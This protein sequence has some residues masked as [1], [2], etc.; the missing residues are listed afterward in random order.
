MYLT[1]HPIQNICHRLLPI[2]HMIARSRCECKQT[3]TLRERRGILSCTKRQKK[4]FQGRQ[5]RNGERDREG[6]N[7]KMGKIEHAL[8][9]SP[10]KKA[11]DTKILR[12]MRRKGARKRGVAAGGDGRIYKQNGSYLLLPGPSWMEAFSQTGDPPDALGGP[13]HLAAREIASM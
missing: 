5:G 9:P 11:R 7:P 8:A 6:K 12:G 2:P 13:P 3:E 1:L 4:K 10:E